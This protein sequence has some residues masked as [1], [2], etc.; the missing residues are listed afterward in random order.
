MLYSKNENNITVYFDNG[1]IATYSKDSAE[2]L[3]IEDFCRKAKY[4]LIKVM[5]QS[6]SKLLQENN[7]NI[8]DNELQI[9]G[10]T[11]KKIKE[12][13]SEIHQADDIIDNTPIAKLEK[14]IFLLK[15]KGIVDTEIQRIKPFLINVFSNPFIK[16]VE[17]IYDFCKAGDFEITEDG[18]IL[19]YKKVNKNFTSV[20]GGTILNKVGTYV[21]EIHFDTDRSKTCSNGLHFCSKE[22]LKNFSGEKTVIVKVNP[23]DIVSIPTDYKH[24]KGRCKKYF[25]VEE[26]APNGRLG[27]IITKEK[28]VKTPKKEKEEKHTATV[29]AKSRVTETFEWMEILKNNVEEVAKKMNIS[30]ETVKR[31]MRR[32]KSGQR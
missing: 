14:F 32:Y 21:E 22:Y 31:N 12:E 4:T 5:S 17:E 1:D 19:A 29:T 26:I 2:Y 28:V 20:H 30:V 11:L 27:T 9:E 10:A 3:I 24:S 16:A 23:V 8:K 25:V 13:A 6:V 18:C 7:I 15:D